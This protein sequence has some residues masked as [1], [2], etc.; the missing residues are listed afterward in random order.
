V[1]DLQKQVKLSELPSVLRQ[2]LR[3]E[4]SGGKLIL[5][6]A[7]IA[8]AITNFRWHLGYENFW[9]THLSIGLGGWSL[10]QDLRTWVNDGLMTVFF[11]VV[12][13]E[14]KRETIS[15]EL[16]ALQTAVLP[17]AAAIGGMIVPALVY[18]ALNTNQVG[19]RGWGIPMATDIAIAVG[20]LM[21]LGKRIP[22]KLKIFLLTLAIVDD[23]GAIIVIAIFYNQ[24]INIWALLA[25]ALLVLGIV[26]LSGSRYMTMPLFAVFGL[27]L[28][29]TIYASG[30]N[31]SITGIVLGLLAPLIA[32]KSHTH[33]IAVRLER[34]LLPTATFIIVPL[35]VF[36]NAGVT[37]TTSAFH[38]PGTLLTAFGIVLGLVMGKVVGITGATWLVV[39][40]WLGHLPR[41]TSWPQLIGIGFLAGVGFTISIFIT[42]LAFGNNRALVDAAKIGIFAGSV[43]S[44]GLGLYTLKRATTSE[45]T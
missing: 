1:I 14:I 28:W 3:D 37:L 13:L 16:K 17:V 26:I 44:A 41:G 18:L 34:A 25:A 39:K 15:G 21:L 27:C 36:A 11:L 2:F 32:T 23:I 20:L 8:L 9:H 29:L 42:E 33:P 35:F 5:L 4:A 22:S 45:I 40:L 19:V 7:L 24:Q 31:A 12:G 43:L 30:I 10:V 38:D 6:A